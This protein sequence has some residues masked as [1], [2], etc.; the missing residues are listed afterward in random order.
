MSAGLVAYSSAAVVAVVGVSQFV[1]SFTITVNVILSESIKQVVAPEH[2]LGQVSSVE[3]VIALAAE[4]IGALVGGLCADIMGES[5]VLYLCTIGLA[6]S[7]AWALGRA[8]ILSF[9]KPDEW[10]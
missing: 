10:Q 6:T 9:K 5:I 3:R 8:G 2:L 4:P 1:W 7:T